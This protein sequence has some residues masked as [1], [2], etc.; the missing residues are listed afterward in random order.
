MTGLDTV[1]AAVAAAALSLLLAPLAHGQQWVPAEN[2]AVY[3]TGWNPA[4]IASTMVP[5]V[6]QG[7]AM[8][9]FLAWDNSTADPRGGVL[10]VP[11][12]DGVGEYEMW[13]ARML[14][15]M[16]YVA[17]VADIYGADIDQG[18]Q[19]P[20][21][22]RGPLVGKYVGNATLYRSRVISA[23][24]MLRN[25]DYVDADN[26]V[27]IGY[28]FGGSGV[29]ELMRSWPEGVDGLKG[30]MGFHTGGLVSS[31]SPAA[32]GNPIA[33]SMQ[34]GA[35]DMS[36]DLEDVFMLQ[37]ELTNATVTWEYT[38]YGGAVHA[39]TE[40][41]LVPGMGNNRYDPVADKRSWAA[42]TSFLDWQFTP[43]E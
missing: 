20:F 1:R 14:A 3:Q 42:L 5:Y 29:L 43:A 2:G 38:A 13:R 32:P 6:D 27:A 21:A 34:Q 19:L 22:Q 36:V 41:S 15:Q 11:D 31:G 16:G 18:P 37:E 35:E 26:L 40:P 17:M 10:I 12:W 33:V 25:A 8:E 4:M 30:V 9:G 7:E 24:E 39:F 23:L 28:C